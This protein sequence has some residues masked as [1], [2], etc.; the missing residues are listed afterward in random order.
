MLKKKATA[1][2]TNEID[3]KDNEI[4]CILF[5]KIYN[6]FKQYLKTKHKQAFKLYA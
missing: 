1:T 5:N 3:D 6:Y 4:K 2:I